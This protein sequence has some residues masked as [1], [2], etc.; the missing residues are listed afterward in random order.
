MGIVFRARNVRL[1]RIVALKTILAGQLAAP[2][3]V[4]RFRIEAENAARLDHPNIVPLYEIGEHEGQ[5]Y[6]TMRLIEG[7]S[8]ASHVMR[9]LCDARAA[10]ELMATVARAVHYAHQRGILHRDLKPA[11]ILLDGSGQPH[12]TDFGLAKRLAGEGD[13]PSS[14]AIVGTPSYMAPE[15]ASGKTMLS[16]A[17]DIFSLG[18]ILYELLTGRSPFRA[19]TPFETLLQVVQKEPER[20]GALNPQV[21]RDLETICLKCLAKEPERRYGSAEALAEDLERWLAGEPIRRAGSAPVRGWSS[22]PGAGRRPR[23]WSSSAPWRSS[24]QSPGWPSASSPWPP[25]RRGRMKPSRNTNGR[26]SASSPP[27]EACRKTRIS[28]QSL[29]PHPR[30]RRTT[31]AGPMAC[32]TPVRPNSDGGSGVHSSGRHTRRTAH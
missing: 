26:W 7:G 28:I 21:D 32:S 24:R 9:F 10:V 15:Q 11:N 27:C 30:S 1:E 29:W 14:T 25:K 2:T 12:V 20:P 18:A 8:L 6:F 5:H 17:I 13:L 3:D 22:G 19:D 4:Q 16:T 31:L 23:P